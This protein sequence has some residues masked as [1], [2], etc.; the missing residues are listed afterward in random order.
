MVITALDV[1]ALDANSFAPAAITQ[2]A[3]TAAASAS[4]HELTPHT[5]I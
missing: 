5:P 2:H 4:P 1:V 3:L